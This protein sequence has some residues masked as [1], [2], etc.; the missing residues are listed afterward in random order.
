MC[1][2]SKTFQNLNTTPM[3]NTQLLRL[4]TKLPF[5]T[6][7]RKAKLER[8]YVPTAIRVSIE[9]TDAN[10]ARLIQICKK[11]LWYERKLC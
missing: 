5:Y 8:L 4:I 11:A 1:P 6:E 10:V 2:I 3:Y 9:P 7:Y